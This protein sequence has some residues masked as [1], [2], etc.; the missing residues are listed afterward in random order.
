MSLAEIKRSGGIVPPLLKVKSR[1]RFFG[2]L[3]IVQ[4]GRWFRRKLGGV[5][6]RWRGPLEWVGERQR[7]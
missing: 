7:L 5:L 4:V 3:A 2:R 6:L 1:Q